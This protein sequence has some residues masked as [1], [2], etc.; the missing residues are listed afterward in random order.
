MR[1]ESRRL[2]ASILAM[3][4]IVGHAPARSAAQTP[5]PAPSAP[6]PATGAALTGA[7]RETQT[8]L[9]A[10]YSRRLLGRR[11]ASGERFDNGALTTAHQ[12]LPFG[13]KV[14]GDQPE[15]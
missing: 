8:G 5:P 15:E 1:I 2:G 7:V 9:A 3:A 4:L 11:T 13:T 12:T 14:R 10:Y 6:A